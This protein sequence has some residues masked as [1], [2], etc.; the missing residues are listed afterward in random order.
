MNYTF[1]PTKL[2][3]CIYNK[4]HRLTNLT[5]LGLGELDKKKENEL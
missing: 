5:S 2:T 3:S 1:K 4:M